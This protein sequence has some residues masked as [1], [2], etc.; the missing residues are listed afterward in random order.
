M[1][2]E[3]K[4]INYL[5]FVAAYQ[6][7]LMIPM[8]I[9]SI[10]VFGLIKKQHEEKNAAEERITS[11]RQA[12]YWNQ[13]MSL[14][15]KFNSDCRYKQIYNR[16]YR[17]YPSSYWD[18][19][20]DLTQ[21]EAAFPF[22]D[23]ICYYDSMEKKIYTSKGTMD[24]DLFFTSVCQMDQEL[25]SQ[26]EDNGVAAGRT[27]IRGKSDSG[28][29]IVYPLHN[30]AWSERADMQYLL[31]TIQ[32]DTLEAQFSGWTEETVSG[33]TWN[34][35]T[36]FS[37]IGAGLETL[38]AKQY[39]AWS[40]PLESGFVIWN[41][42]DR[43]EVMRD[44]LPY[45]KSY[46]IWI[47]CSLT[48]GVGLAIYYSRKRYT[49]FRD[50]LNT[51]A[52]LEGERH[53]LQAEGCLYELLSVEVSKGSVLW[54]K[55]LDSG[56]AVDCPNQYLIAFQKRR[57]NEGLMLCLDGAVVEND[58]FDA[59]RIRIFEDMY[60][61]LVCAVESIE[62]I[63][64]RLHSF[65]DAGAQFEC[66]EI[67]SNQGKIKASFENLMRRIRTE[68]ATGSGYPKIEMEALKEAAAQGDSSRMTVLLTDL[69]GI[70]SEADDRLAVLIGVEVAHIF[71]LDR[72]RLCEVLMR[73]DF[74]NQK[75]LDLLN[76]ALKESSSVSSAVPV[77]KSGKTDVRRNIA[78]VLTFVHEH[79]L[80]DEFSAKSMAA[81]FETSVS[82]LSHFFKKNMNVSVSQYVEQIKMERARELLSGSDKK[83]SEIAQSLRYGS[84]T[85]FINMFK[86]HEGMTPG[87]YRG[88]TSVS[89]EVAACKDHDKQIRG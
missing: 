19:V 21:K 34:G 39:Q 57:E 4:P 14:I 46:G 18:I 10:S 63:T 73:D 26:A 48:V 50:L 38:E 51:N 81:Y 44:I 25:I 82:N 89:A 52:V 37:T 29:V 64:E 2:K 58:G 75:I 74:S 79:Y 80:E 8:L 66:S 16:R 15:T 47:T 61:Y 36:L 76:L 62:A 53:E 86:K 32:D 84:S 56:I 9:V 72:E 41:M 23:R 5:Q 3:K 7:I 65:H 60:L 67:V 24:Q 11:Q 54:Q 49:M 33:I 40:V 43:A 87:E 69:K 1:N 68:Q 27:G 55:C 17:N 31:Y 35:T 71:N 77:R 45:I 59:Y 6:L 70:V 28:I 13:Q 88:K 22:G 30:N 78:D 85:L 12:D 83:I 20:E 42:V